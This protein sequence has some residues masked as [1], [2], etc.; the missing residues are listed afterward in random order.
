M[1]RIPDDKDFYVRQALQYVIVDLE[2]NE[3]DK[4]AVP[5]RH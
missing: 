4:R 5:T 3:R 2:A 1:R